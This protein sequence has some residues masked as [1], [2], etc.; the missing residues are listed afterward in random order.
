MSAW[1]SEGSLVG[2]PDALAALLF[3]GASVGS[4]SLSG[5]CVSRT[6]LNIC[7]FQ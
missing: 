3:P 7:G 1:A 5:D 2:A 6:L 4:L